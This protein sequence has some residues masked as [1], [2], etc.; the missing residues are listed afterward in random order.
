MGPS[1]VHSHTVCLESDIKEIG[2]LFIW[3][4]AIIRSAGEKIKRIWFW[5]MGGRN[6]HL[7]TGALAL[8]SW[9]V[10]SLFSAAGCSPLQQRRGASTA[11]PAGMWSQRISQ[12]KSHKFRKRKYAVEWKVCRL[13]GFASSL[14]ESAG[15]Q[16]DS[17]YTSQSITLTENKASSYTS[18][19]RR[20][21][22]SLPRAQ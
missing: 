17:S 6:W 13:E 22:W 11:E 12:G 19:L 18:A 15:F 3:L 14:P 8:Q 9:E 5:S 16:S 10:V 4:Q 1:Q 21:H 7:Q 20:H 2:V